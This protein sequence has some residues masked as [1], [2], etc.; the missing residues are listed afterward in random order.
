MNDLTNIVANRNLV[1]FLEK[2]SDQIRNLP[3]TK[4][5]IDVK[6]A[7]VTLRVA[8]NVYNSAKKKYEEELD[9]GA[10]RKVTETA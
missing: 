2:E 9:H 5:T 8:K 6:I 4:R 1:Q 7:E 3:V 10:K